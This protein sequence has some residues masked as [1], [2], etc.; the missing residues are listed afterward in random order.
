MRF[1]IKSTDTVYALLTSVNTKALLCSIRQEGFCNKAQV[2]AEC[3]AQMPSYQGRQANLII[4]NITQ[5]K[6]CKMLIR[7]K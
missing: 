2:K 6:V 5:G 4:R 3:L 1:S 7:F